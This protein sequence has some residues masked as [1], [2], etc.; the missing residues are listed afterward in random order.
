MRLLVVTLLVLVISVCIANTAQ[1]AVA[2]SV[3]VQ[4]YGTVMNDLKVTEI[5]EGDSAVTVYLGAHN[6][7]SIEYGARAR[8][9][10]MDGEQT[11]FTGWSE[12][13]EL[14]PGQRKGF[15]V[16]GYKP[17][18]SNLSVKARLYHGNE[19]TDIE[20]VP[21][22]GRDTG[23]AGANP[24]TSAF[25]IM[26]F[27]AYDSHIRFD[28]VSNQ[29]VED[30]LIIPQGLPSTWVI[31]QAKIESMRAGSVKEVVLYYETDLFR[32]RDIT[33]AA[34][35]EDGSYYSE[36]MFR[37]RK[38]TGITKYINL[39]TDWLGGLFRS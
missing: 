26:N 13:M 2:G 38:E 36:Q 27:R 17:E 21:I 37:L 12:K 16:Y 9:D 20:P 25:S 24:V 11:L 5:E 23:A 30:V 32:E 10:I 4:I 19:I 14:N 28:L 8:I 33:I 6:T 22:S 1:P 15:V 29:S 34:A 18:A 3:S 31:E 39:F 35:T 7:G